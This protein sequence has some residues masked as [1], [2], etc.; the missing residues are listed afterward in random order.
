MQSSNEQ[1]EEIRKPSSAINAKKQRKTTEW[2][3]LGISSRKLDAKGTFHA[4]MGSIK[5]RNDMDLIEAE[6]IKKR[7][8]EY[9]E[10]LCK[11]DLKDPENHN[12]VINT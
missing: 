2:E 11:K 4:K 1:Q 3:R 5:D 7:W 6:D 9:T 12:G 10:E 8:Q